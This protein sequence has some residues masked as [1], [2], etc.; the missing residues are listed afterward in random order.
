MRRIVIAVLVSLLVGV[1]L[2]AGVTIAFMTM[3]HAVQAGND[4]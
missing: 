4:G 3:S 1:G 2:G